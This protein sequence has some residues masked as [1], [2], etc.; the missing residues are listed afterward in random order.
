MV[1]ERQPML[2]PVTAE[3]YAHCRYC[4]QCKATF[5]FPFKPLPKSKKLRRQL[6][7]VE[8]GGDVPSGQP[9]KEGW[10]LRARHVL[11]TRKLLKAQR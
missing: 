9:C 1:A 2:Y 11:A 7:I 10:I 4:P 6:G 5:G 8:D 3:W